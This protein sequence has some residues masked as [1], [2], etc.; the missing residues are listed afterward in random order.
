MP[1]QDQLEIIVTDISEREWTIEV[2]QTALCQ[3]TITNG[4]GSPATF[5]VSVTGVDESW[6]SLSPPRVDLAAGEQTLV[7]ITITP[8]RQPTSYAG[9]YHLAIMV[10]SPH[11]PDQYSQQA[12]TLIIKPYDEFAVGALSPKQQSL[13]N[14]QRSGQLI[15]PIINKSNHEATFQLTGADETAS[16]H[17]EFH[18]P[19]EA[20]SLASP[21]ELR[22]SSGEMVTVPV[23]VTPPPHSLI[24]L[25]RRVYPFTITTTIQA[26]RQASRSVLGRLES[27]P[28]IGPWLTS[29]IT[30]C[31]AILMVFMVQSI[32]TYFQ[33]RQAGPDEAVTS[34]Q[35]GQATPVLI[36]GE[37][38]LPTEATQTAAAANSEMTYEEMFQE[39]APQYELE[40]R[41]LA[42]L[43]Y[44]E[45]R[46]D[47]L[48]IG[49]DN[50][51]GLMQ[52]I[53]TTWNEWAPKVGVSDPFDP[54][55]NI[56]VAA[57]YL[58][59]LRDY[60]QTKGYSEKYWMLIGY[61][62]GPDNLRQLFEDNGGW[63]EVPERQR[64][65]ALDILQATSE[66]SA[67]W[68]ENPP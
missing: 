28:L 31:L 20:A 17:F 26:G 34:D 58:A 42:E 65:Y 61:N 60:S 22:L 2:E 47:P 10:T 27:P 33:S 52:I 35:T 5:I 25:S 54:Y 59:Y 30:V 40:W 32:M 23:R 48:A 24:G 11:Y 64:R 53:P 66:A 9:M 37:L 67:R 12:A 38:G 49:K 36:I 46:M 21:A 55:S 18:L 13:S 51:M 62:W 3:L 15:I 39:I 57:A 43:A 6:L 8:P 50:D 19:G 56:L 4:G 1:S 41:L 14:R 63:N 16:C 7:M 45:S 44:Q 68:K 29:L